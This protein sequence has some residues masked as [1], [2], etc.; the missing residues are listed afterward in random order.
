MTEKEKR[1]RSEIARKMRKKLTS[2]ASWRGSSGRRRL[3]IRRLAE[4]WH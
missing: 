3:P 1:I 4:L 2:G